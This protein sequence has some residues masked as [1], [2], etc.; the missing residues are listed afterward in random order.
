MFCAPWVIT[1]LCLGEDFCWQRSIGGSRLSWPGSITTHG[2]LLVTSHHT[3]ACRDHLCSRSRYDKRVL[4]LCKYSP[5]S[6]SN[7]REED[8]EEL[9]LRRLCQGISRE[10]R[11]RSAVHPFDVAKKR[12]P[13]MT[14]SHEAKARVP[15]A[16]LGH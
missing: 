3:S 7:R 15:L 11:Q 6:S 10:R 14:E 4:W 8:D 2:L 16:L 1:W 12:C 13:Q 9:W 5:A